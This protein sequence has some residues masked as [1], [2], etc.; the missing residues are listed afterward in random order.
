MGEVVVAAGKLVS[1]FV[2]SEE[3]G[4]SMAKP[5]PEVESEEEEESTAVEVEVVAATE[6]EVV[7]AT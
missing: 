3:D 5:E 7:V 2:A 1:L 4:V 6:G